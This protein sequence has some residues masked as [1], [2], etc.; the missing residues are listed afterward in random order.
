LESRLVD[1]A[2]LVERCRSGDELAWEAFVRRFQ[3]QV[4]SVAIHY[5]RNHE[6]ARD[7]AQEIFVRVYERLASFRSGENLLPWIIQIGRNACID[8]IRRRQ[9][10]PPASD[11][12]VEDGFPI[13]DEAPDPEQDAIAGSRRRM[14]YAAL[15]RISEQHRE[16]ILLKEIQCLKLEEIADLLGVPVGTVKSR[17]MRARIELATVVRGMDPSYGA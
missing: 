11:L 1:L 10:R 5:L 6:E 17:S 15:G 9:A 2:E 16:M 8:R 13:R 4:F 3:G 14:L 7:A 12:P